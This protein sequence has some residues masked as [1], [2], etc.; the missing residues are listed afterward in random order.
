MTDQPKQLKVVTL[1]NRDEFHP[2]GFM[3]KVIDN[4]GTTILKEFWEPYQKL[5]IQFCRNWLKHR[6]GEEI[7]FY[8]P[9]NKEL[10]NARPE[11]MGPA[12]PEN[13]V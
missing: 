7:E 3:F 4:D 1:C 10:I 8:Q 6:A 2:G 9:E 13:C 12:F 5:G 11:E